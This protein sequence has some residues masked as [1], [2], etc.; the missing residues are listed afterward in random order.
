MK[1][2]LNSPILIFLSLLSFTNQGKNARC[3]VIPYGDFIVSG[4]INFYQENETSEVE[5]KGTIF[6]ASKIHGF[7]IHENP[8]TDGNCSNVGNDYNPLNLI[9]GGPKDTVRHIGDLGN[10]K[11]VG[12]QININMTDKIISLY[13]NFTIIGKSCVI[14][15]R[16]DDFGTKND[17]ESK[18][19]GSSGIITACGVVQNHYK[20][21]GYIFGCLIMFVPL[22]ILG[23]YSFLMK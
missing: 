4:L 2:F 22:S 21:V 7:H 9:H 18:E 20:A 16:E 6:G 12:N 11:Q 23:Y 3:F 8:V 14:H 17:N 1:L 10:I 5:I 15:L 19:N 13:N